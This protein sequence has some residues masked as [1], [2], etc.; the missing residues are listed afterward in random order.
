MAGTEF[1][2]V[3]NVDPSQA[4]M[5]I[6]SLR[7]QLGMSLGGMGDFAGGAASGMAQMMAGLARPPMAATGMAGFA[8]GSMFGGTF[9]NS[10][11]AYTPHY[12]MVQAQTNLEQEW[13]VHRYGLPAAQMMKPPGVSAASF[14]FGVESNYQ[15]RMIEANRMAFSAARSTVVAGVAG[16]AAGEVTGAIGG[17]MGA[18]IGGKF[19]G[20]G[21]MIGGLGGS[22]LGFTAGNDI[23]GGMVQ[24]HYAQVE[25]IGQTTRELGEIAGSGRGINRAGRYDLG[26][27]ARQAAKDIGMDVQEMGD[28][29]AGGRAMGM[30]PTAT[31]PGKARQQFG[32]FAKAIEEG[33]QMLGT[34]LSNAMQV[35]KGM[36]GMG[37]GAR[38]GI[39]S[40]VGMGAAAGVSPM[41]V[42]G[43]GMQGAS[44]ARQNLLSGAQ[45][46]GLFTGALGSGGL[47]GEELQMAGG[48]MGVARMVGATQM[49]AATSPYGD[50]QLLAAQGGGALGGTFDVMS[51]ALGTLSEGGDFIGN[52]IR[53]STH[54]RELLR[55]TGARGIQTMA[56]NQLSAMGDLYQMVA[57]SLSDEDAERA[58][59][60]SQGLNE[61]EAK[62]YVRSSHGRGRGG[63][64]G[65]GA[66]RAAQAAAYQDI[67]MGQSIGSAPSMGAFDKLGE[68]VS[69]FAGTM[70]G[71]SI[72][73]MI[74]GVNMIGGALGGA[75]IGAGIDAYRYFSKY[76][77]G[78]GPGLFASA[79]EKADYE[80]RKA[81]SAHDGAMKSY[82]S[83]TGYI[84]VDQRMTAAFISGNYDRTE[85]DF[86]RTGN[87]RG[88]ALTASGL[89]LAGVQEVDAGMGTTRVGGKYF[90][91]A[92]VQRV[93][94]GQLIERA[95]DSKEISHAAAVVASKDGMADLVK[96]AEMDYAI[97]VGS[98]GTNLAGLGPD[99]QKA[100]ERFMQSAKTLV[101]ASGDKDLIADFA[102]SGA[103]GGK[104]RGFFKQ[105]TGR[106]MAQ[107]GAAT[108]AGLAGGLAAQTMVDLSD[109]WI[110]NMAVG[111][112]KGGPFKFSATGSAALEKVFGVAAGLMISD[113]GPIGGAN[114]WLGLSVDR[115]GDRQRFIADRMAQA[116]DI[117]SAGYRS[118]INEARHDPKW[119][120]AVR[121]HE[122]GKLE[123]R[124]KVMKE[125]MERHYHGAAEHRG[126]SVEKAL[127]AM[128]TKQELFGAG[129]AKGGLRAA[130]AV[131]NLVGKGDIVDMDLV[132]KN[133]AN[134]SV[135][136]E[137]VEQRRQQGKARTARHKMLAGTYERSIG[138]G[139]Q[140]QFMSTLTKQMKKI[141]QSLRTT[142]AMISTLNGKV[143]PDKPDVKGQGDSP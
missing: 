20:I 96:S 107:T 21:R 128:T 6:S 43:L 8:A 108:R 124:D 41:A 10:A 142:H 103:Q 4:M 123:E 75:A 78:S 98:L 46:F 87:K 69:P 118:L 27:A 9:T 138:F 2:F 104:F 34:S 5:Q 127:T 106:E 99:P 126:V 47:G 74:P 89:T 85:L 42:Y 77:W 25:Q 65:G 101:E 114:N 23:V 1:N 136:D 97:A 19:G 94:K 57:P 38:E 105:M 133:L 86:D 117:G 24:D 81:A 67:L 13:L 14:A 31:D 40:L 132:E 93:A 55:S 83:R 88:A 26:V 66:A 139:E 82:K 49:A 36:G 68:S 125:V 76:D 44:Y 111:N 121:L 71:A 64:G 95:V 30:L 54:K 28:I 102:E 61:V 100:A 90:R 45:G 58:F 39:L 91:T 79:E 120:K 29:L 32:E 17:F 109:T 72:G 116:H 70:A 15:D 73:A 131:L 110:T 11:M 51:G 63:G 92:D 7:A 52:A 129:I 119:E 62:A 135:M 33:A 16:M 122:Q 56:R 3:A 84:D 140:E 115:S 130:N 112:V 143:N 37:M 35:I 53:F 22:L 137:E 48:P 141:D 12:G 59:M 18:A 80:F 50:M 113:D 60:M 134:S